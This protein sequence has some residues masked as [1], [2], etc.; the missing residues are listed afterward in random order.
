MLVAYTTV[1]P[2]ERSHSASSFDANINDDETFITLG[3]S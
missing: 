2:A 1:L 3:K